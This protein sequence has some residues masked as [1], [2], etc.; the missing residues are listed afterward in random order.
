VG[1]EEMALARRTIDL[2]IAG[3]RDG[4]WA[5]WSDDCV[6]VPPRDWPEPGPFHG[7]QQ[8]REVFE[9]WNVAFGPEWTSHMRVR[10]MTDLGGGRILNE[11][12]FKSS[13]V[14]SGLPVD[15]QLAVIYTVSG[16]EIVKGDYFMSWAEARQVA[17]LE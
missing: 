5:L 4:A 9:S 2:F 7:R 17:G 8:N 10:E 11:M 12:E 16:G 15:Q 14:E 6:G 3:D 13:G 1:E